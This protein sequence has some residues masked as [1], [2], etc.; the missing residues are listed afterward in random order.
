MSEDKPSFS[1][2]DLRK[3]QAQSKDLS[4]Q[5]LDLC[6]HIGKKAYISPLK[7]K[8]KKNL[9]KS[10]ETE[11][12]HLVQKNFDQIIEKYVRFDADIDA[13]TITVQERYQLLTAIRRASAG[14]SVRIAHQ[15]PKCQEIVKDIPYDLSR[16]YTTCY[17]SPSD[18]EGVIEVAGGK[19]RLYMGPVTRGD[20]R[21]LEK[22]I[23][24]RKIESMTEQQFILLAGCIKR[25]E[26]S[27]DDIVGEVTLEPHQKLEFFEGLDQ[28]A[29]N[30]ISEYMTKVN[31]GVHLPFDFTCPKCKYH[32]EDEEASIT[33]FFIS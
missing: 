6:F 7:I 2:D 4:E 17:E 13:D 16:S 9:L 10:M 5:Q 1:L 15:C 3:A 18:D 33:V 29:L 22:I 21:E 30:R 12:Q 32:N 28:S 26:L 31:H 20:E 24:A 11:D 23:K 25:V 14:D 19:I 27:Q 8:D